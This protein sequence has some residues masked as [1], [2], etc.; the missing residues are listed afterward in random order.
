MLTDSAA[1]ETY[2]NQ[3]KSRTELL[4]Y[5]MTASRIGFHTVQK[6]FTMDMLAINHITVAKLVSETW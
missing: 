4:T 1:T 3:I 6:Y 5:T 2:Q